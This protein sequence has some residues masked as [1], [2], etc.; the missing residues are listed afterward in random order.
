MADHLHFSSHALFDP[1]ASS[2]RVAIIDSHFLYAGKLAFDWL[3][4]QRDALAFLQPGAM[5]PHFKQQARCIDQQ[6]VFALRE[7]LPPS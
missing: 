5:H 7:L 6:V 2:A 4:Q 3:Q 1:G